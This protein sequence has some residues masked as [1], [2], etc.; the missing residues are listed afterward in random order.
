MPCTRTGYPVTYQKSH[1]W[2]FA[3]PRDVK[4]AL[5]VIQYRRP[6][7]EAL[8]DRDLMRDSIS[9]PSY[10]YRLTRDHYAW[11]LA[12]KASYFR[13]FHEKW[14]ERRLPN[15]VYLNYDTLT[16]QPQE[17]IAPIVRW[18][19]GA[20]DEQ[21]L[22][23]AVAEASKSRGGP[24]EAYKPRVVEESAHFDRD[25]L[26][27]FEDYVLRHCPK[28]EFTA[29][30]PGSYEGHFLHGLILLQDPD[31]P[32]PAGEHDRLDAAARLAPKHPEVL[33]RQA[34][35]AL[36]QGATDAGLSLLE[37]TLECSPYFGQAYRLLIDAC[38]SAGKA[39]PASLSS[40]HAIFALAEYPGALVDIAKSMLDEER[41][42]NAVAA[43]TFVTV[44]Q[45]D[46]FR[47]NHLLAK[48]LGNLGRWSEAR[49]YAEKAVDI[50]PGNEANLKLLANIRSHLGLGREAAA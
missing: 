1:D 37:E 39:L 12:K 34:R 15:S 38:K 18:V 44:I 5:Y 30:L 36:D 25:L 31:V 49:Q 33:L 41:L 29:E 6:V 43:L 19:D 3:L 10:N 32:L 46:N 4:E 22:A 17:A 13:K 7:P 11:W 23:G 47:A 24:R 2:E 27:A 20:V 40:S 9:G 26:S 8:S 35:R 48:T 28:L 42:V 21:K 16:R 50:K 14:F 45:P